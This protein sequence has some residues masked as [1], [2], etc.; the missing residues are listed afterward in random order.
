MI[1][2]IALGA[3][4]VLAAGVPLL[5]RRFGRGAGYALALG[6]LGVAG[7]LGSQAPA[8]IGGDPP[9]VS[10]P[11]LPSLDV[12][13][14]LRLDGLGELF[15]L[16]VLGVG[17]LVMAYC[18]RYLRPDQAATPVYVLLTLFAAAML[19]LVLADDLVLLYVFWELTTVCSF[20]LIKTAGVRAG[21]PASRALLVTAAGGLALLAAVVLITVT[22]GTTSLTALLADPEAVTSSPLAGVIGALVAVAAFTK[23]AQLPFGFWLPGAMVAMTPVSAYLHAA[24][25]V[26]AGVYLLM[27]FSPLFAG[28]AAWALLLIGVGLATALVGAVLALR[29]HDLKAVL[30]QSTVSQLGLLVAVIG[31]GTPVALAAAMLHTVAHALFK[32]TL[33]MLVGII[34]R[35]TGSRD[36][37]ELS[38]LW[39]TM[40][41]TAA[42]T[43]LAALSLAGVPPLLGFVSKEYLLLGL[44]DAPGSAWVGPAAAALGVTA[45]ALTFAYALRVVLGALGGP[46]R[47]PGLY[48]PHP[49]FLVPA[50]VPALVGLAL[51]PAVFLL[52]PVVSAARAAVVPGAPPTSLQL[53]PGWTPVLALSALTIVAGSVLLA[54]RGRLERAMQRWPVPDGAAVFDRGHAAVLRCG[55]AVAAVERRASP[56]AQLARPVLALVV[57]GGIAVVV[58]RGLPPARPTSTASDWVVLVV[59]AAAVAAAVLTRHVL[60]A[61]GAVGLAGLA[62]VAWFVL[63]GAPDVA[64]TLLL[65]EV[66][67]TLVAVL[68]LRDRS[69]RWR[70]DGRRA[71]AAAALLAV[72]AGLAAAAATL[73]L[74]GRRELSAV[75]RYLL[76][77]AEAATGGTN[78]VNT[79]LVDFRGTDTLGEAIV[80]GVAALGLLVLL[81]DVRGPRP[82]IND[83][84]NAVVLQVAGRLLVPVALVL[85][86]VLFLRG[87]D[88]PGGGFIAALVAGAALACADL[89]HGSRAWMPRA[90]R[91][92]GAGFLIALGTGLAPLA[93]GLPFLTPVS[94]GLDVPL[95]GTSLASTL[96][97]ELGV[98]L[99]VT[100]LV[101]AALERL[102]AGQ[103]AGVGELAPT[104]TGR[105]VR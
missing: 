96:L 53:W 87:H 47:Q 93:A 58:V 29:E 27:R 11:W 69:R 23:S 57:L 86:V 67:T 42:C 100:G 34:D 80:V 79:V 46:T 9:A 7:M 43:A 68:V 20:F 32:A 71:A 17:A 75:G 102:P 39:R 36:L 60:A 64:L 14:A 97:F 56:A 66:L 49:G 44:L 70:R 85:S 37:R 72:A 89:A 45:S 2:L 18:P 52:D 95:V 99:M 4:V 59:L 28:R 3:M 38:G 41:R 19:G 54:V 5:V 103:G 81:R 94:T 10:W 83:G 55:A 24:T 101:T 77:T 98:F 92:V 78:V 6:F 30:A 12:A 82:E 84:A 1:L 26:K 40:P 25:M 35:E 105:S 74:T 104:P 50:A 22:A 65:V 48:D 61:L 63:A 51:G 31:V 15:A 21:M 16:L 62:V 73:A 8:V 13:L 33:F 91:L 88:E 76:D 90:D